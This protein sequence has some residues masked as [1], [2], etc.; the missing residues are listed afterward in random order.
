MFLAF[1]PIEARFDLRYTKYLKSNTWK[2]CESSHRIWFQY[3][4]WI[5]PGQKWDLIILCIIPG[6]IT[7]LCSHNRP[8]TKKRQDQW[9]V[10]S[11]YVSI[12]ENHVRRWHHKNVNKRNL[13]AHEGG[14]RP[15]E[16]TDLVHVHGWG[17]GSR[18]LVQ[19]AAHVA[20]HVDMPLLIHPDEGV[21]LG[22]CAD[23]RQ[24]VRRLTESIHGTPSRPQETYQKL[25]VLWPFRLVL[26]K[27]SRWKKRGE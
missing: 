3:G 14:D 10:C 8:Y 4:D 22:E 7:I 19:N 12:W 25:L 9:L 1:N 16:W 11:P 13:I 21:F 27:A 6:F 24:C 20:G 18:H 2:S 23:S 26:R 15:A 5:S 17:R